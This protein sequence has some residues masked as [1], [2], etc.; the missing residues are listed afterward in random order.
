MREGQRVESPGEGPHPEVRSGSPQ[1]VCSFAGCSGSVLP[2][3]LL[4]SG[5]RRWL[6]C[7]AARARPGRAQRLRLMGLAPP[8]QAAFFWTRGQACVR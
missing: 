3:S 5:A 8:R 6:P 1:R 2:R 4:A 7:C